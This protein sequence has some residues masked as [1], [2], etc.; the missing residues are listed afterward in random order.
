MEA[1]AVGFKKI[2]SLADL[3]Q[4]G[5]TDGQVPM[6]NDTDKVWQAKPITIAPQTLSNLAQSSRT[7]QITWNRASQVDPSNEMVLRVAA[8]LGLTD[9]AVQQL[10]ALA[11]T[12]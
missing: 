9:L 1:A 10:F 6:W 8:A 5:A 7:D 3:P 12:L 2:A 11:R 4:S